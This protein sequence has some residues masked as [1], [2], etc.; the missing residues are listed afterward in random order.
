MAF[1]RL[2]NKFRILDGKIAGSQARVAAILMACARLHNFIIEQDLDT[3][4]DLARE[5]AENDE[6]EMRPNPAAP[7]GMSY[8]PTVADNDEF[9]REPGISRTREAL[10]EYLSAESITRPLYNIER[11][12]QELNQ[13]VR[14]PNGFV[15]E[16]AY[17]SPI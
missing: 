7:L 9:V 4:D 1:G 2:V 8:L 17:I 6:D 11:Q 14:S 10:V 3:D 13:T 15:Q 16:R 5:F 12:R